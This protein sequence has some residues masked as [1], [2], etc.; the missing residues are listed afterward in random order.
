M[1]SKV[2]LLPGTG[3]KIDPDSIFRKLKEKYGGEEVVSVIFGYIQ[4][5]DYPIDL[6]LSEYMRKSIA[7]GL[8]EGRYDIRHDPYTLTHVIVNKET[9]EEIPRIAGNVY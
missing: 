6:P 5:D 1:G 9:G 4:D 8:I 7:D 2:T 3:V